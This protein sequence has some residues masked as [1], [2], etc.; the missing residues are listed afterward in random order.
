MKEHPE[1]PPE[2]PSWDN[3][4]AEYQSRGVMMREMSKRLAALTAKHAVLVSAATE[5]DA[6]YA[7]YRGEKMQP[8]PNDKPEMR[9]WNALNSL[10]DALARARTDASGAMENT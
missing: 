3:V 7:G 10:H 8:H 2:F 5:V 1:P 6:A 4:W 9:R